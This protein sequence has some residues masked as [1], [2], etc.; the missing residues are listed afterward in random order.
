MTDENVYKPRIWVDFHKG[1]PGYVELTIPTTLEE[2]ER[3]RLQL[4]E[5][6]DIII[7]N[8]D[9][10]ADEPSDLQVNATVHYNETREVWYAAFEPDKLATVPRTRAE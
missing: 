3:N 8:D 6:L 9:V 7:Y 1:G 10:G 4:H 2:L 5:G